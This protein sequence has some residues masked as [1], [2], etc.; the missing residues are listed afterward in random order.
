MI[1]IGDIFSSK[2]RVHILRAANT[3]EHPVGIRALSRIADIP[4]RSAQLAV[5]GLCEDGLLRTIQKH[6]KPVYS[7]NTSHPLHSRIHAVFQADGREVL[8]NRHPLLQE[9]ATV[10]GPFLEEAAGLI[11]LGKESLDD[12]H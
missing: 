4:L 9:K 12:S 7:L 5:R 8:L 1:S 11:Q 2:A 10:L 6:Q 3:L